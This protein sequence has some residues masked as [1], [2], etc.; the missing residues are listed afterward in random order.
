MINHKGFVFC[1]FLLIAFATLCSACDLCGC[2]VPQSVENGFQVGLAEQYSASSNLSLDGEST[3]NLADQHMNSYFTQLLIDYRFNERVSVQMNTPLIHRS[4]R[5]AEGGSIENGTESGLGDILLVGTYTPFQRKN[6]FSEFHWKVLGGLKM[7]TGNS[8]LI[9]EELEEEHTGD[10]ESMASGVHGHDLALGSGSWDGLVG[11]AVTG[12]KAAWFFSAH[13]QY[14]IRS[15]GSFDYKYANDLLWYGG[16]GY[17][18]VSK[19]EYSLGLQALLAGEHKGE[20][21]LG[22]T[23]ADDTAINAVY[24]GPNAL[25]AIKQVVMAEIGFGFPLSIDNSGLQTVPR[26]RLHI[27]LTWHFS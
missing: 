18:A 14:A 7:P 8:D 21:K 26:Y 20:D 25:I 27:G 4:F 2:F 12:R 11:A 13:I 22:E 9:G 17:Y 6:P 5:R 19:P 16:P 15:H 3:P 10:T 1:L 23:H 24:V